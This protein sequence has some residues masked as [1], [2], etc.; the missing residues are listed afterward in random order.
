MDVVDAEDSTEISISPSRPAL[1]LISGVPAALSLLSLTFAHMD[2]G[3]WGA[4]LGLSVLFLLFGLAGARSRYE[5][6]GSR[7]GRRDLMRFRYLDLRSLAEV[8]AWR[9]RNSYGCEL[10][11]TDSKGSYIPVQLLG[12][13]AADRR[14][15]LDAVARYVDDPVVRKTGPVARVLADNRWW[16]R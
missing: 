13:R 15:L 6:R 11:F 1:A 8:R 3:G 4:W 14:R 7:L 12:Y 10:R 16:P 5:L 2:A 9:P